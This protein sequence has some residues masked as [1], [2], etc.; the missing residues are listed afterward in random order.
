MAL[1]EIS[2]DNNNGGVVCTHLKSYSMNRLPER[3]EFTVDLFKLIMWL[4]SVAKP[5]KAGSL[6]PGKCSI[7]A[8]LCSVQLMHTYCNFCYILRILQGRWRR[9]QTATQ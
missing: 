7:S 1:Y 8:A 5:N 4:S 9:P 2:L 3:V 6:I